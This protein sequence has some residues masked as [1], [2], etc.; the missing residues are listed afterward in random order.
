MKSTIA[1]IGS[2]PNGLAAAITLARAGH[3]VCVYEAE[4]TPGGGARSSEMTLP[5]FIHDVCSAVHPMGV[6]SPFFRTLPL[7]Q[8]GL[9]W[10]DPPAAFAHPLNDG[11]AVLFEKSVEATAA[12]LGIDEGPYIALMTP[13][14][15]EWERLFSAILRP[16]FGHGLPRDPLLL[17]RFGRSALQSAASFAQSQFRGERARALFIGVAAHANCPLDKVGTASIALALMIAG[18][19]RGWPIV[20]GGT[21]KLT[22]ALI[23]VLRSHGGRIELDRRIKSIADLGEPRAVLCDL[24][25]DVAARILG[26]PVDAKSDFRHGNGV[27]KLDWAL[28]SPIPWTAKEIARAGTVHIGGKADEVIEAERD[29][30]AARHSDRPYVLLSQ[31]TLF[32]PSRAPSGQHAAWAYCHVPQGSTKDMTRAIESQIERFAPG[33]RGCI[34]KTSITT[35]ADI[36]RKNANMF[37]GDIGGGEFNL[38]ISIF[39]SGLLKGPYVLD[40]ARRVFLCSSATPPGPGVH[41]MCGF[42]A[43][44]FA[45]R[46][47]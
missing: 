26:R 2:G 32:D 41:G 24:M 1:I 3:D 22:D 42:S 39:P 7:Q 47:L 19:A 44:E 28:S 10:I 15:K 16:V 27:F 38:W 18:H 45:L 20:R 30:S 17:A 43:A 13:L 6:S 12:N 40:S 36:E 37:G 8:H 46:A 11:E 34:M 4:A 25:P 9:A 33:F 21:Q 35:T 5:G 29:A 31:P 14:V 23:D